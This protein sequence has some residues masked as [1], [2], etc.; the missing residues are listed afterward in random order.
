[1]VLRI[2]LTWASNTFAIFVADWLFEDIRIDDRWRLVLAGAV[3]GIVNWLVKPIVTLLALPVIVLT[4]G[5]ALFFVNLFMLY[6]T[7]WIVPD[8]E[9]RTFGAAVGGTAVIW[10]INLVLYAVFGLNERGR[11]RAAAARQ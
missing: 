2:L 8:F 3:F 1:M 4:V 9:I 7:S 10:L 6:L 11:R 5:I